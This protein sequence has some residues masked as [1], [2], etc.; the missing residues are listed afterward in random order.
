MKYALESLC[1]TAYRGSL[2]DLDPPMW[3][4][5]GAQGQ[6]VSKEKAGTRGPE[7]SDTCPAAA[8][9]EP[10]ASGY[11]RGVYVGSRC[12]LQQTDESQLPPMVAADHGKLV[13]EDR[14]MA[15]LL[16]LWP[17]A[18]LGAGLGLF[19]W[20]QAQAH[21]AFKGCAKVMLLQFGFWCLENHGRRLCL[22]L[23]IPTV[24]GQR[25]NAVGCIPGWL[26][27][28]LAFLTL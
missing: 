7:A 9:P 15:N 28:H 17:A 26:S 19:L 1:K 20:V 16:T 23:Y 25:T 4:V 10:L 22:A 12:G 18:C 21:A 14:D 27:T 3:N 11:S 8:M 2:S 6:R 5:A 13:C 24:T